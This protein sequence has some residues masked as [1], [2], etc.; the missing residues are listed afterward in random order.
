MKLN[1]IIIFLFTKKQPKKV[2]KNKKSPNKIENTHIILCFLFQCLTH[3]IVFF[4]D[5]TQNI[6]LIF[7]YMTN[8]VLLYPLLLIMRYSTKLIIVPEVTGNFCSFSNS[9][10]FLWLDRIR[11]V[12]TYHSNVHT[13]ALGNWWHGKLLD[14]RSLS[15]ATPCFYYP[16][17]DFF[18]SVVQECT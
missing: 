2:H 18:K 14:W 4:L 3:A 16:P 17:I 1:K 9:F 8:L 12:I 15:L 11:Y 6:P 7:I 13:L 5:L 10:L